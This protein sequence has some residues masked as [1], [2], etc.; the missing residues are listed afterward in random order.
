MRGQTLGMA[1]RGK[2]TESAGGGVCWVAVEQQ[3]WEQQWQQHG[4]RSPGHTC[5]SRSCDSASVAGTVLLVGD[6]VR[7]GVVAQRNSGKS[8]N[9]TKRKKNNP[10]LSSFR[11]CM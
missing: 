8:K 7:V 6:S 1:S 4:D 11:T 10:S 5:G 9:K 2:K 3:R